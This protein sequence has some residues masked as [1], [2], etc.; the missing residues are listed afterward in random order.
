MGIL[1]AG[2][3]PAR[4]VVVNAAEHRGGRRQG[5]RLPSRRGEACH[6]PRLQDLQ[7]PARSGNNQLTSLISTTT[8]A[9]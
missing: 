9:V 3:V 6:L 2:R 1:R 5:P 4:F 8:A 7:H